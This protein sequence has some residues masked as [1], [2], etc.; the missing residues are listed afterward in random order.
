MIENDSEA[1]I[2]IKGNLKF[3]EYIKLDQELIN[4]IEFV[5]LPGYDR[6]KK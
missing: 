2:V 1:F 3:F 6:K 5:D 4:K